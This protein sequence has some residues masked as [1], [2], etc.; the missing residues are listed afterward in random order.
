[1]AEVV[2][3]ADAEHI[4]R[5]VHQAPG[6]RRE[7]WR[8]RLRPLTMHRPC[9]VIGAVDGPAVRH[10]FAE[11]LLVGQS[12]HATKELVIPGKL[13]LIQQF[14]VPTDP[15]AMPPGAI[16]RTRPA[17]S[18]PVIVNGNAANEWPR[19]SG[20]R[21]DT[22]ATTGPGLPGSRSGILLRQQLLLADLRQLLLA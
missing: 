13:E 19:W 5:D 4:D 17:R 8:I 20:S 16:R 2:A 7:R 21:T 11:V 14:L 15:H 6:D 18:V 3:G 10:G 22:P 12:L 9:A 1:V